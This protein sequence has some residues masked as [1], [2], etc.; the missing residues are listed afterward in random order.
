MHKKLAWVVIIALLWLTSCGAQE[1]ARNKSAAE[2]GPEAPVRVGD[3]VDVTCEAVDSPLELKPSVDYFNIKKGQISIKDGVVTA[4]LYLYEALPETLQVN[5]SGVKGN[6]EN[7]WGLYIDADGD[8][9][10]GRSPRPTSDYR[11][12]VVPGIEYWLWVANSTSWEE[13][14]KEVVFDEYFNAEMMAFEGEYGNTISRYPIQVDPEAKS[15]TI[16]ADMPDVSDE[17]KFYFYTWCPVACEEQTN[18]DTMYGVVCQR[19]P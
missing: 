13:P 8:S 14:P 2:S 12:A 6:I 10:T 16:T 4:T 17:S 18:N 3:Q 15:I 11:S 1:V 19:N 9:E 7:A 5:I